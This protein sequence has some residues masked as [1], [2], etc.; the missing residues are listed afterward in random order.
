MSASEKQNRRDIQSLRGF[1]V[2]AVIAFHSFPE[3]FPNGYLGVD[4]FLVISGFLITPKILVI[5]RAK[6]KT[7]A[8]NHTRTFAI[9]RFWRLFPALSIA[10]LLTG[11]AT[12]A[13][14]SV[15]I[16]QK[17]GLQ[18]FF[19][20]FGL[21][22]FSAYSYGGNYFSPESNP[23]IHLWSLSVEIQLY[24]FF[25]AMALVIYFIGFRVRVFIYVLLTLSILTFAIF[26]FASKNESLL[27]LFYNK[28]GFQIADQFRYYSTLERI[29]Q[30]GVGG[31]AFLLNSRI[32]KRQHE[33]DLRILKILSVAILLFLLFTP[34][35]MTNNRTGAS[36]L[37]CSLAV[38]LLYGDYKKLASWKI[39]IWVGDR[40]Y[41][42][43][44]IH[45]PILVV[46]SNLP[47]EMT[48]SKPIR[49]FLS[50][51][52]SIIVANL[53]FNLVEQKFRSRS[54]TSHHEITRFK[55]LKSVGL[56]ASVTIGI[57]SLLIIGPN[58][59]YWGIEDSPQRPPNAA[60][61]DPDCERDTIIGP[62][63]F[64]LIDKNAKT[65]L[66]IGDSHAG[67]LS[68]VFIDAAHNNGW[69][70][71]V[72]AHSG[73]RLFF[74]SSKYLRDYC[75]N[76]NLQTLK[77]IQSQR[78]EIVV[79]S[80]LISPSI[81]LSEY[82]RGLERIRDSA[83]QLIM[84]G[85][86]PIFPDGD[87]FMRE[88]FLLFPDYKAPKS[89]SES[90]MI[91]EFQF[92]SLALE[93]WTQENQIESISMWEIYCQQGVCHRKNGQNWLFRDASHLSVQGASL[94]LKEFSDRIFT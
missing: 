67:H 77:F 70:A 90:K 11:I 3:S 87:R 64:Y 43:Y 46:F 47:S 30:F 19:S 69:N 86:T 92:A 63:C 21:G 91:T 29:W 18:G 26:L 88:Q 27:S 16:H 7:L 17:V 12:L 20:L 59:S 40:S 75:L 53:L 71:I 74:D 54:H 85:N 49:L 8:F 84:L 6:N 35:V 14:N 15:S 41:S 24:I 65:A 34:F 93:K 80:Q 57:T 1:A 10:I 5:I 38:V 73:C 37:A 48:P 89:F 22:N 51:T 66:L 33:I 56:I 52:L 82:K 39:L 28:I 72:W 25:A 2:L 44:L 68:Q 83:K 23:L 79:V 55:S 50:I 42:L 45:L 60:F 36:T 32:L 61:L 4:V 13:L 9:Q 81:E 78:P 31:L 58:R 94:S 76:G 62:P